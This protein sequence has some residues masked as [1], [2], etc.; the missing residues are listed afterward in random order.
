M[1]PRRRKPACAQ[2]GDRHRFPTL[3]SRLRIERALKDVLGVH[4]SPAGVSQCLSRRSSR[5]RRIWT[6]VL[7]NPERVVGRRPGNRGIS[8]N[9]PS[10]PS[11]TCDKQA[12]VPTESTAPTSLRNCGGG[13]HAQRRR[14]HSPIG[15]CAPPDRCLHHPRPSMPGGAT[16][17]GR[18]KPCSALTEQPQEPRR[19]QLVRGPE[20]LRAAPHDARSQVISH[21]REEDSLPPP[22]GGALGGDGGSMPPSCSIRHRIQYAGNSIQEQQERGSMTSST[23]P[24]T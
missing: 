24:R 17:R 6:R 11:Y 15:G 9:V 1:H 13:S 8:S 16:G 4:R 19:L 5:M 12:R 3:P 22:P 18:C 14:G 21:D 20:G 23:P 7:R 2:V 10:D